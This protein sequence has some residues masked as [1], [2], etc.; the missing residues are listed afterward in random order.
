MNKQENREQSASGAPIYR[1]TEQ[2]RKEFTPPTGEGNM[3]EISK[4]IEKYVG[5]I[6]LVFHELM[7]DQVHIDI[8]WVKPTEERPFHTLVTSGMSDKPMTTPDGMSAFQY[9]ELSICLPAEWKISPEDFE[10]E[11][12]YWPV[13]WLKILS[14]FPHEFNTWLSYGHTIP[15]GDPAEPFSNSTSLNTMLL[16]PSIVFDSAFQELK[17]SEDKTIRFFTIYPVYSE[18]V[19]LKLKKGTDALF[20]GFNRIGLTDIVRLDRENS[21]RRKKFLG[22]F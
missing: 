5:E 17:I 8:H 21:V 12:N 2:E 3:E 18:E 6:H 11:E 10:D 19:E 22:V 14:R 1:Y 7:S 13:R 9:A 4:H 15:N 16:L 20:D